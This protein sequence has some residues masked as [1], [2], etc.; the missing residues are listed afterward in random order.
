M[1]MIERLLCNIKI[2]NGCWVWQGQKISGY[3]YI[4]LNKAEKSRFFIDLD[5]I[6]GHRF[7]YEFVHEQK[8][9]SKDV[10]C[11]TCDNRLCINPEHLKKASRAVNNR[12]RALNK[13]GGYDKLDPDSIKKIKS[14]YATGLYSQTKIASIF[15][16][17][18]Q[19]ISAILL[20]KI[21]D[22]KYNPEWIS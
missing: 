19:N 17:T 14:L 9:N 16:C 5:W 2:Q 8:L 20:G 22:E 1:F 10:I 3:S 11:H 6:Y 15:G 7:M 4:L 18:Q 21:W 12:H 13:L